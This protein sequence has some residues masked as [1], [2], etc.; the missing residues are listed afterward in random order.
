MNQ[1]LDYDLDKQLADALRKHEAEAKE[2][3]EKRLKA[4]F[5]KAP[6]MTNKSLK[7]IQNHI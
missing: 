7:S 1:D 5:E 6:K 4:L 3:E 2:K